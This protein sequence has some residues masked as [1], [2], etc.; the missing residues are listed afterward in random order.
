MYPWA[1]LRPPPAQTILSQVGLESLPKW[2]AVTRR[3]TAFHRA[4]QLTDAQ[5]KDGAGKAENVARCLRT[6][7]WG[8]TSNLVVAHYIGSWAK[9]TAVRPP[10]DVDLHFV[11]PY[12]VY[13]RFQG[14]S[15]NKQ[16][17]LLQEVKGVLEATY[18]NTEMR[19]DR[20][21]VLVKFESYSVEVVP[22]LFWEGKT[23]WICDTQGEGS[24]KKVDPE[25]ETQ[26][27]EAVDKYCS[28]NLRPLIR[29]LKT[30]QR[31]CNVEIK[32]FYLELLAAEF[33]SASEW[34]NKDFFYFDWITR[35]FFA[36]LYHRANGIITAPGTGEVMALGNAWQSKALSAYQRAYKACDFERDNKIVSAGQEWQKI[37]GTDVPLVW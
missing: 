18:S 21:V 25:A 26:Y 28:G 13:A 20:Q 35:D 34:R 22:A 16:S 3:L 36:F 31:E 30:W 33:L 9:K 32:S 6:H 17:A 23:F 19:A 15:G 2:I 4:I 24:Y 10:R 12:E 1:Q 8:P 37:F 5:E 7:Y 29:M 27:V 14:R 11:I